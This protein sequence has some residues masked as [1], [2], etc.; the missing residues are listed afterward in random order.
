MQL[1]INQQTIADPA[2]PEKIAEVLRALPANEEAMI[3]LSKSAEELMQAGGVPA[4]GFV[5]NYQNTRTGEDWHS[6]NRAVKLQTVIRVMTH[7]ARDERGWRNIIAWRGTSKPPSWAK[8]VDVPPGLAALVIF[9]CIGL[10]VIAYAIMQGGPGAPQ[11]ADLFKAFLAIV[12]IAGYIQYID[13]FF[14][15][16]RPRLKM[17]ASSMLGVSIEEEGMP[18]FSVLFGKTADA[19]D[20]TVKQAA[21]WG[22]QILVMVL[23]VTITMLGVIGPVAVICIPLFLIFDALG[24]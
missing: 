6:S 3:V 1:E 22:T 15:I 17:M 14:R 4:D 18:K 8:W 20:W 5:L 12:A 23:D 11:W 9:S 7:F 16:I 21:G 2:T 24:F 13:L 19:E 10:P